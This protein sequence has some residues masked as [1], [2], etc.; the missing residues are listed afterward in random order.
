MTSPFL[1]IIGDVHGCADELRTLVDR[2]FAKGGQQSDHR[3]VFVGDLVD[4]GPDSAGVVQFVRNL[5]YMCKVALVLGNHEERHFRYRKCLLEGRPCVMKRQEEMAQITSGLD[6][7]DKAFLD[8]AVPF[9][10]IPKHDILVVHAGIP[11]SIRNIPAYS[12]PWASL[13]SKE[14]KHLSQLLRTR[15]VNLASGNMIPLGQEGPNDPFWADCYDGA[16]GV[17]LFGHEAFMGNEPKQFP[18]AV[19]LDMG[20]VYGGHLAALTLNDDLPGDLSDWT[21]IKA[22]QAWADHRLED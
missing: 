13:S 22:S 9:L 2:L 12:Q 5:S 18:H 4:K 21:A 7:A 16:H 8:T 11:P 19:S 3:F 6:E 10:R 17:V 1:H 20:C 14:R 15:H